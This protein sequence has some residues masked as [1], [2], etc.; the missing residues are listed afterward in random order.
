MRRRRARE[1]GQRRGGLGPVCDI[2]HL[3][4]WKGGWIISDKG[5]DEDNGEGKG[6]EIYVNVCRKVVRVVMS[7]CM[8][9]RA[10]VCG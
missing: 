8:R 4:V 1:K 3:C 6:K 10:S 7:K 9:T 5:Q 2:C